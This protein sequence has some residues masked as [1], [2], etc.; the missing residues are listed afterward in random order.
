MNRRFVIALGVFAVA[1]MVLGWQ[2]YHLY[3]DLRARASA[4]ESYLRAAESLLKAAV[5]NRQLDQIE[6]IKGEFAAARWEF[7]YVDARLSS[8]GLL[9]DLA[10]AIPVV[11]PQAKAAR[12]LTRAGRYVGEGGVQALLATEALLEA[13]QDGGGKVS[14]GQ[15]LQAVPAAAQRLSAA[16]EALDRARNECAGLSPQG[17]HP[18]LA[19]ALVEIEKQAPRQRDR[20]QAGLDILRVL[21]KMLGQDGERVY[22]VLVQ[23]ADEIRPTGGFLGNYGIIRVRNGEIVEVSFDDVYRVDWA[24]YRSGKAPPLPDVFARYLPEATFW[25]LR[26]SNIWPD[27]QRSAKQAVWF[28]VAEGVAERVDG[29]IAVTDDVVQPMM[30]AVGSITVPDYGETVTQGNVLERI[31]YH[32][33]HAPSK[34]LR[35]KIGEA[36]ARNRK[37]FTS[38]V[39]RA[40]IERVNGL[41]TAAMI[42]LALSL[43]GSARSRGIQMYF[44]DP[45][46]Q[47]IVEGHDLA[48]TV[49]PSSGDYLWVVDMNLS[50]SKDNA[51]VRPSIS[52]SVILNPGGG[53]ISQVDIVYDYAQRHGERYAGTVNRAYY[54]NYLRVYVP[55]GSVL[56]AADGADEPVETLSEFGKTAFATFIKQYPRTVRKVALRYRQ[57]LKLLGDERRAEYELVVQKQAGSRVESFRATVFLPEGTSV[58]DS[59]LLSK[60]GNDSALTYSGPLGQDLRLGVSFVSETRNASGR[61]D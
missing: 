5:D 39:L 44:A 9:Y 56:L 53:A 6:L 27:F 25:A 16:V 54:G 4:A 47:K 41:D 61:V 2:A 35:Q 15:V 34:E 51:Y 55:P 49:K 37:Y 57:P 13:G 17:L 60:S 31:R 19:G 11:G 21:P 59:V 14:V 12:K 28:A 40:L 36:A 8:L 7:S 43:L 22:L 3:H 24:Y 38:L 33:S 18:L 10:E 1:V 23:D 26:D 46:V 48:G 52:Y 58:L 20:L 32:Q 42:D 50:A 45:D 30:K 29:V